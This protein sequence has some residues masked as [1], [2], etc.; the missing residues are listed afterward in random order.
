MEICIPV[1]LI[2]RSNFNAAGAVAGGGCL[3]SRVTEANHAC[4]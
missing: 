1:T 3:S 2:F 4:F